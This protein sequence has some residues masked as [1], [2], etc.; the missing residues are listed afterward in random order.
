MSYA[1]KQKPTKWW[2]SVDKAP[3]SKISMENLAKAMK[4]AYLPVIT[5]NI[6]TSRPVYDSLAKILAEGYKPKRKW[7]KLWLR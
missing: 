3:P 1:A 7:W 6:Y 2:S 4:K 5:D